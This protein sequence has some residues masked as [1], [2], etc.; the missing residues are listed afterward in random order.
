MK[1]DPKLVEQLV[2]IIT[3][4]VLTAMAEE[5]ARAAT[6]EGLQC[7]FD[8][9]EG[10]CVRVCTD[11]MG[12]VV[13]AGATGGYLNTVTVINSYWNSPIYSSVRN[14]AFSDVSIGA[15]YADSVI[16]AYG[17]GV[18]D[19]TSDTT[20]SPDQPVTRGEFAK[21]LYCALSRSF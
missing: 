17:M 4:E 19:A 5:E 13:N 14:A 2:E 20:F 3:H 15:F 18:A 21:M 11:R 9:A 16:R 10:L 8:C 7:K 1:P 6:P 12:N